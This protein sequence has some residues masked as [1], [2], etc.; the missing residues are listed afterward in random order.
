MLTKCPYAIAVWH[1]LQ[2][3]LGFGFQA[4]NQPIPHLQDLVAQHV[5]FSG[6]GRQRQGVENNLYSV[7]RVERMLPQGIRQQG[8]SAT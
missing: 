3:W 5:V 4:P 1:G 7:E 6:A 8:P 2:P